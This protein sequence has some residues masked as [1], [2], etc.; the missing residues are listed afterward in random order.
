MRIQDYLMSGKT[1]Q[2]FDGAIRKSV[3]D[4]GEKG[5][6]ILT[7]SSSQIVNTPHTG[8]TRISTMVMYPMSLYESD[9]SNG[10]VSLSALFDSPD[11]FDGCTFLVK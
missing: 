10:S 11:G 8:T 7:G 1:L 2:N 5:L 3:D 9:E 6:Y 4:R